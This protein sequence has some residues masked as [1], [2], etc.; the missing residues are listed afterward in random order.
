MEPALIRR[1]RPSSNQVDQRLAMFPILE[2]AA[3][4]A[5]CGDKGFFAKHALEVTWP[6]RPLARRQL[7]TWGIGS[8]VAALTAASLAIADAHLITEASS[9][10]ARRCRCTCLAQLR[11]AR[12]GIAVSNSYERGQS[13]GST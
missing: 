4:G 10:T 7:K 12:H 2:A 13:C 3:L 8:A 11:A 9:P 5:G 1:P 6:S